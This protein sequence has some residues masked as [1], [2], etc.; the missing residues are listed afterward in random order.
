MIENEYKILTD[1]NTFYNMLEYITDNYKDADKKRIVQ[2][3]YYYDTENFDLYN[4]FITFR[5]RQKE[6]SLTQQIKIKNVVTNTQ[7]SEEIEQ[8]VSAVENSYKPDE[9]LN[10]F[11]IYDDINLLGSL[12]TERTHHIINDGLC[13]D[14]DITMYLGI[15]DYEIEIEYDEDMKSEAEKIYNII[16]ENISDRTINGKYA[17]FIQQYKKIY[18]IKEI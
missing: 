2:C 12:V 6:K 14:F 4:N 8:S 10:Q 9:L 1:K 16:S 15:T 13:I 11:E 18:N 17:R 3:N 5:I 7:I